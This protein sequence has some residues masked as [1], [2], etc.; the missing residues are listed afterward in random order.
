MT[1]LQA[2]AAALTEYT[3][4]PLTES[5]IQV[6]AGTLT[7]FGNLLSYGPGEEWAVRLRDDEDMSFV[8]WPRWKR[9]GA[10]GWWADP[11]E[12]EEVTFTTWPPREMNR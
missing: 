11:E 5:D 6:S 12:V 4:L 10:G 3:G 9:Y 1:K 8:V 2:I 7:R